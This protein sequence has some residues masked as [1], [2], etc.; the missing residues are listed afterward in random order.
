MSLLWCIV[1]LIV[2]RDNKYVESNTFSIL[3]HFLVTITGKD[4]SQSCCRW[5]KQR[6]N[7]TGYIVEVKVIVQSFKGDG[8]WK[9]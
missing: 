3:V 2:I 6:P 7:G 8:L 5:H 4:R 1:I 9:R